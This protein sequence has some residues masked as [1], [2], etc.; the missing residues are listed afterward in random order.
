M[1]DF[2]E[3]FYAIVDP[4]WGEPCVIPETVRSTEDGAVDVFLA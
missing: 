4:N 2:A 1:S 3:T